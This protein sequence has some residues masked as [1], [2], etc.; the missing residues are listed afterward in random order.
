MT[1]FTPCNILINNTIKE[2]TT[3]RWDWKDRCVKKHT[4]KQGL[5]NKQTPTNCS[6]TT[7]VGPQPLDW[8]KSGT[9]LRSL[10]LQF[11]LE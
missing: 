10:T 6:E 4:H 5:K 7:G 2:W 9:G 1:T 8:D 3:N 11:D